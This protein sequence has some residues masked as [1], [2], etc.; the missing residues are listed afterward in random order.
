MDK[1]LRKLLKAL[2]DQD[3]TAERTKR[4]HWLIRDQQGRAVTT[5]AGTPSCPRSSDNSLARLRRAGF[6]WPPP[7]R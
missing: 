7:S 6:V 3:F 5:I 2:D 4:Q 1:G